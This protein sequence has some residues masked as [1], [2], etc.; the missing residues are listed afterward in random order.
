M[1]RNALQVTANDGGIQPVEDVCGTTGR[2]SARRLARHAWFVRAVAVTFLAGGAF[3][4]Y[5]FFSTV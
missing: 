5:L 2:A 1:D 3:V 4:S